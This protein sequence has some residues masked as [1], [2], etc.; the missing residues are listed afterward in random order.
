M[1]LTMGFITATIVCI[2]AM[3]GLITEILKIKF[4]NHF[5]GETNRNKTKNMF[6][7]FSRMIRNT[8]W[9]TYK[10]IS[11]KRDIFVTTYLSKYDKD[12][13][14][15]KDGL[16]ILNVRSTYRHFYITHVYSREFS[17]LY[18]DPNTQIDLNSVN[19]VQKRELKTHVS[20]ENKIALYKQL[21]A[22][23]IHSMKPLIF[24]IGYYSCLGYIKYV[25]VRF[26]EWL[27]HLID[28]RLFDDRTYAK[29]TVTA[30]S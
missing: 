15:V 21:D 14:E 26:P 1:E 7:N 28:E 13:F 9:D 8:L 12:H 20:C 6:I 22:S 5:V 4:S 16:V 23:K 29:V 19:H 27:M 17:S 25:D 24:R 3:L 2:A 11:I 30:G 10:K 18:S